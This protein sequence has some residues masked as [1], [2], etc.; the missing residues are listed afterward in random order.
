VLHIE[1]ARNLVGEARHE[2]ALVLGSDL[3]F[4]IRHEVK[5]LQ[6]LVEI[7]GYIAA[8]CLTHVVVDELPDVCAECWE[9]RGK[10]IDFCEG[11]QDG[12]K[13]DLGHGST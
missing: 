2:H 9:C 12:S 7:L 8:E 6:V 1:A 4:R 5:I 10:D 3:T 11:I 13:I